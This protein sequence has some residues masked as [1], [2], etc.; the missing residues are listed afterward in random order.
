MSKLSS[1]TIL[2][3]IILLFVSNSHASLCTSILSFSKTDVKSSWHLKYNP[4]KIKKAQNILKRWNVSSLNDSEEILNEWS[5]SNVF[6]KKQTKYGL[7]GIY[8]SFHYFRINDSYAVAFLLDE[9]GVLH[10][11]DSTQLSLE[12]YKA[13]ES[14]SVTNVD[15]IRS[16][17]QKL[18]LNIDLGVFFKHLPYTKIED[19]SYFEHIINLI[20]INVSHRK[21]LFSFIKKIDERKFSLVYGWFKQ[22]EYFYLSEQSKKKN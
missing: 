1:I 19:F 11:L 20:G 14:E 13:S 3:I 10:A 4:L 2:M 15:Y 6:I 12:I 16:F 22:R 17:G 8:G 21:R 7:L 9:K 18:K 5:N